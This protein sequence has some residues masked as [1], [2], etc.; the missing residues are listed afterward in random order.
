MSYIPSNPYAGMPPAFPPQN[1]VGGAMGGAFP[2]GPAMNPYGDPMAALQGM[3]SGFPGAMPGGD[4][5]GPAQSAGSPGF[6]QP[7]GQP[8]QAG[9]PIIDQNSTLTAP[10]GFWKSWKGITTGVV[11]TA[12]AGILLHRGITGKW[13]WEA[14]K[15]N[16][17][18]P[19]AK[20]VFK[21]AI[22]FKNTTKPILE[23]DTAK[24][25]ESLGKHKTTLDQL[26]TDL[27]GIDADKHTIAD[28]LKTK[29]EALQTAATEK[30]KDLDKGVIDQ[31][32]TTW[33][34]VEENFF[35]K[36]KSNETVK[37]G[38]SEYFTDTFKA[39]QEALPKINL[40]AT[41]EA[42]KKSLADFKAALNNDLAE[43][44]KYLADDRGIQELKS[45]FRQYEAG[46]LDHAGFTKALETLVD[47]NLSLSLKQK[48]T[49]LPK[50][51]QNQSVIDELKKA[52]D[53]NSAKSI[54][55]NHK[56]ALD[57]E[58]QGIVEE[59]APKLSEADKANADNPLNLFKEAYNQVFTP[60]RATKYYGCSYDSGFTFD[61]QKLKAFKAA[62]KNME[63]YFK[64]AA[65]AAEEAAA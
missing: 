24:I 3:G 1:G 15:K 47:N 56:T 52:A 58:F 28:E 20:E 11:G 26:I 61:P 9:G 35:H 45:A 10:S 7:A 51:L 42:G 21:S 59:A 44:P 27:K 16:V 5:F 49:G 25:A 46:K 12:A 50:T 17:S 33:N 48:F 14:F 22:T 2:G 54:L 29:F 6:S 32:K 8:G 4:T 41:D 34:N 30:G 40:K 62:H 53:E 13:I 39:H 31:F 37:T 60:T 23:G 36:A 19:S 57:N 64:E 65:K 63:P 43:A 18:P 38:I 55:K